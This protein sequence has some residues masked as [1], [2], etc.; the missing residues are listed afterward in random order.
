MFTIFISSTACINWVGNPILSP[1]LEV[2]QIPG[3]STSSF[4]RASSLFRP[5]SFSISFL[6][7]AELSQRVWL[8]VEQQTN[9]K[10]PSNGGNFLSER[11]QI[12]GPVGVES[13]RLSSAVQLPLFLHTSSAATNHSNLPPATSSPS[14]E[15][16]GLLKPKFVFAV[17]QTVA[18]AVQLWY[19]SQEE[20]GKLSYVSCKLIINGTTCW[21]SFVI[22]STEQRQWVI[23]RI[24]MRGEEVE[25]RGDFIDTTN[26]G[27]KAPPDWGVLFVLQRNQCGADEMAWNVTSGREERGYSRH[28]VQLL[29][30]CRCQ[31]N[32]VQSNCPTWGCVCGMRVSIWSS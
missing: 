9:E 32:P 18:A 23:H 21:S 8:L 28:R 26:G 22:A 13:L 6:A 11:T 12:Y 30:P 20:S 24:H 17:E 19:A 4:Y 10:F 3:S 25:S 27:P 5:S 29:R 31:S 15:E 7:P 16:W 1:P 2:V 14:V